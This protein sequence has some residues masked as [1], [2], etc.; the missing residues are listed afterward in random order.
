MNPLTYHGSPN[1]PR[2]AAGSGPKARIETRLIFRELIAREIRSGRLTSARRARIVRYAAQMG[3]SAVETGKLIVE[4]RE[5]ALQGDDVRAQEFA[6][7]L[8]E[9]PAER[10]PTVVKI[11]LV[12]GLAL[13]VNALFGKWMW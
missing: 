9:P 4:C 1:G 13:V 3:L 8:V 7:R 11:A 2:E 12:V 5:E 6:L 10:V